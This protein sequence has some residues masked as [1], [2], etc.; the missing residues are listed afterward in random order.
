MTPS[1]HSPASLTPILEDLGATADDFIGRRPGHESVIGDGTTAR[2]WAMGELEGLGEK[3]LA[4][5][6]LGGE[7]DEATIASLREAQWPHL[8]LVAYYRMRA[9]KTLRRAHGGGAELGA[10][11]TGGTLLAFRRASH[12]LSPDATREKFDANAGGWD[13]DPKSPSYPHFRWMRRYVATFHTPARAQRVLD[14]GCGAGW[15][16]IESAQRT[17]AH[18]SAFDPSPQMVENA[19]ANARANGIADPDMRVGFG[20]GPPHADEA[21]FDLVISAGVVSFSPDIELWIDGLAASVAPGGTLVV[22]DLDPLSHGMKK[23]RRQ[24][25]LIP[26]RELNAVTADRM[27]QAL[28]ARGF[29]FVA[30]SDYQLSWPIPQLMH[31]NETRMGG[32]L[33]RPL[34]WLNAAGSALDGALGGRLGNLFDSWVLAFERPAAG[35]SVPHRD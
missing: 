7:P 21:P 33:S 22:A 15:V 8:H 23:R 13:D 14:F 25:A 28:E 32:I 26:I 31:L 30:R 17:G 27:R 1:V 16:G 11:T 2:G 19:R 10:C 6:V 5:L 24:K 20:E 9:G 34:V 35:A 12:V 3:G 29:R 18:L 4:L